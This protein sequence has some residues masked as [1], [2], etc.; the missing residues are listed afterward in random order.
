M[1][2]LV[3]IIIVLSLVFSQYANITYATWINSTSEINLNTWID[4]WVNSAVR[5]NTHLTGLKNWN[6]DFSVANWGE[7][8]IYNATIKIALSMKNFFFLLS[9]IFFPILVIRLLLIDKTDTEVTNFKKWVIWISIWIIIMQISYYFI[10]ILLDRNVN[11]SLAENFIDMIMM[12]LISVLETATSFL[13]LA[14]MIFAFFRIVTANWEDAKAKE[15]KMAVFYAFVWFVVVKLAK[16]IV[17]TTYWKSNCRN[18]LLQTNCVNQTNL[19]WFAQ[20]IVRVIDWMN[21]FVWIVV[22][23]MIIYAWFLVLTSFGEDEKL[24]KAKNIVIYIII[25]LLILIFNYLI[26][27]FFLIPESQI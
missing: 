25:W 20:I 26:L 24:K 12:P 8:W 11:I 7:E 2:T 19:R 10:N 27:T 3:K 4:N 17:A 18:S 21:S 6:T 1:K 16:A 9:W 5:K 23:I 15:W 22:I 13:F 14:I